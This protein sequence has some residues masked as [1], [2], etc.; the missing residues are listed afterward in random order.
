V[1][2]C[3]IDS[4]ATQFEDPSVCVV[5]IA[6]AIAP[7]RVYGEKQRVLGFISAAVRIG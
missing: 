2:V 3:E 5:I 1:W 7:I 4:L 6:I